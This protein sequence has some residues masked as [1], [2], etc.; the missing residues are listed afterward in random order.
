MGLADCSR[1][2]INVW[3]EAIH[4]GR[5]LTQE[6]IDYILSLQA[7]AIEEQIEEDGLDEEELEAEFLANRGIDIFGEK[8]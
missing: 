5:E 4:E 6:E 1:E 7:R 3:M 8:I 2:V